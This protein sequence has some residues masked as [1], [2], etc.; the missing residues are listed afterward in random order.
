MSVDRI[1]VAHNHYQRPGGEDVVFAAEVNLLR[2][3]GHSVVEFTEHNR[4]IDDLGKLRVATRAVWSQP[5]KNRLRDLLGVSRPQI[6]HFHNTFPLISPSAYWACEEAGVPVVQTLH[7]YRLLCPAATFYRNDRVCQDCLGKRIAWPGVMHGCYRGSRSQSAVVAAMSG[8]HRLLS[9]WTKKVAMFV[10]LTEDARQIFIEAGFPADRIMVKPNF[11]DPDPGGERID[12]EPFVIF[13][14]RLSP[15]KGVR[16]LVDTWKQL[17]DIPLKIVGGGPLLDEV[18]AAVAALG[19]ER[20]EVLG[21]RPREEVGMLMK[22]ARCLISPQTIPYNFGLV[23]MEALARRLP[24]VAWGAGEMGR[25]LESE[26]AGLVATPGDHTDLARTIRWAMNHGQQVAS[27]GQKGRR[28]FLEH[29]TAERNYE[30]LKDI[31]EAA[32]ANVA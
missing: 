10:V 23:E 14:G 8:T 24:I 20:V 1:L 6:A 27:M 26:Q 16:S 22:R 3:R 12:G 4:D 32:V 2:S 29:Y 28:A 11:I 21:Q 18:R 30:M 31:Y 19:L 17:P 7:N 15:E 25:I 13:V 5:A 9:T